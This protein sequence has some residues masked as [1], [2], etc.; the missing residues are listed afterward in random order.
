M[1]STR[2][3]NCWYKDT[4]QDECYM[5]QTYLQLKWQMDN[6]GLSVIQQKP[7]EMR[8][9]NEVDRRV[10]KWLAIY[11]ENIVENTLA[12]NNLYICSKNTGNGKTS[13]AIR[14][15]HSYLHHTAVGNYDNLKGMFI[16]VPDLLIKLKDWDNPIPASYRRSIES[17][18]LVVW[19]DI[20]I[21]GISSFDYVQLYT[22]L[23]NRLSAGKS[24][25]IT[26]NCVSK[27]DLVNLIGERLATRIWNTS[28]IIEF[29]GKDVR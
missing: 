26:G 2:E 8:I 20:A 4:C 7:I 1:E 5:C 14:M 25:I 11:R 28:E 29:K 18:D 9:V 21:A 13:W 19:D 3:S 22:L 24:N 23:N 15:L 27:D 6:S 10:Y 12:G 17:V 16:S